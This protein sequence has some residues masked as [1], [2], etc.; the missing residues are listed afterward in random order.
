MTRYSFWGRR[1]CGLEQRCVAHM[2]ATRACF[3]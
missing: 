2:Q 1:N 3:G